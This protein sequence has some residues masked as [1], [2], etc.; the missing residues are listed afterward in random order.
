MP[1]ILGWIT[2]LLYRV[3]LALGEDDLAALIQSL[4]PKD[5]LKGLNMKPA[6]FEKVRDFHTLVSVT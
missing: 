6:E 4:P 1:V 2:E 3:L 5:A